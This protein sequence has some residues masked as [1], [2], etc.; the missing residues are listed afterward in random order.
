MGKR[1]KNSEKAP[2]P[3]KYTKDFPDYLFQQKET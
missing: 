2:C 3:Y 1:I